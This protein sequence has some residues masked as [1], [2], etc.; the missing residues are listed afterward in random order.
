MKCQ[1]D[2]EALK[3]IQKALLQAV[4]D[5]NAPLVLLLIKCGA[6]VNCLYRFGNT[7]LIQE[8]IAI[9]NKMILRIL[10]ENGAMVNSV[11]SCDQTA[12]YLAASFGELEYV[13]LLLEYNADPRISNNNQDA[14]LDVA[15]NY[16]NNEEII[17]LITEALQKTKS[18]KEQNYLISSDGKGNCFFEALATQLNNLGVEETH[19]DLRARGINQIL[20]HIDDY[21]AF[22]ES[23]LNDYIE[24]M[25]ILGTWAE[26]NIIRATSL[27]INRNI[28]V[29]RTGGGTDSISPELQTEP[30]I[31]LYYTGD[32]YISQTVEN[33]STYG[34]TAEDSYIDS[35]LGHSNFDILALVG[36]L[37]SCCISQ[38]TY[39]E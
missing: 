5:G 33:N 39:P 15:I 36:R 29:H 11:N 1:E 8:V 37:F 27:A 9:E 16:S 18:P 31:H 21:R 25:S 19:A 30:T 12:L 24:D 23:P 35:Y 2:P 22:I 14:I 7:Y 38:K 6:D 20:E 3:P 28:I 13:K 32:H 17:S 34:Y 10:L 26:H 4:E